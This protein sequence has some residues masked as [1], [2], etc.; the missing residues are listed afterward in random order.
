M[1]AP[2]CPATGVALKPRERSSPRPET[3]EGV[4]DQSTKAP[5]SEGNL[6]VVAT[7]EGVSL[8]FCSNQIDQCNIQVV[9]SIESVFS[10]IRQF[11]WNG[12]TSLK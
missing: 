10:F 1:D 9:F 11:C 4:A 2:P 8:E 6:L 12:V 3:E 5:V 7:T